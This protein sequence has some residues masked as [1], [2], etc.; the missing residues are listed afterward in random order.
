M[1][2]VVLALGN[3]CS[4]QMSPRSF[5]AKPLVVARE[6]RIALIAVAAYKSSR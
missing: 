3:H 1:R 2:N 6:M 4:C 5:M